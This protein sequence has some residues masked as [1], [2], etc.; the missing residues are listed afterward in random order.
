MNTTSSHELLNVSCLNLEA[1]IKVGHDPWQRV[2]NLLVVV[3]FLFESLKETPKFS[4]NV[5]NL[6][7][8]GY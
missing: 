8:R 5:S 3:H 1:Y 6:F 7:K 4:K 2:R